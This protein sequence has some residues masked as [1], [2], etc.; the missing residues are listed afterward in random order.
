MTEII[1]FQSNLKE[2][3]NFFVLKLDFRAIFLS[4]EASGSFQKLP[5]ASG[6]FQKLPE[7]SGSFWKLPE[8]SEL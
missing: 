2:F 3:L 6:S 4:D 5:E 1:D 7:A 8:V